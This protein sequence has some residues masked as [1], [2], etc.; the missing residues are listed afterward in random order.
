MTAAEELE[1]IAE[2]VQELLDRA[3]EIVSS[4]NPSLGA[5]SR[6]LWYAHTT[7]ALTDDHSYLGGSQ[8]TLEKTIAK[9]R[10]EP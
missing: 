10:E 8:L 3:L 2:Q 7:M 4:A 1:E 6:R 5:K 9:L